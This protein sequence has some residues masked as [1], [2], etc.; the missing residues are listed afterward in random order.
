MHN[1]D[2]FWFVG[3][4][5]L[6]ALAPMGATFAVLVVGATS[7]RRASP[8]AGGLIVIGAS[9]GLLTGCASCVLPWITTRMAEAREVA[10]MTLMTGFGSNIVRATGVAFV[11]AGIAVLA[12]SQL[13]RA[14][15]EAI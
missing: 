8:R 7:V 3:L 2:D 4:G 6:G 15:R 13:P 5:F 9:I 14:P 1:I 11:A 10:Q 12:R